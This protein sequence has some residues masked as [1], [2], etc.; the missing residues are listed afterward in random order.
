MVKR[1]RETDMIWLIVRY[2]QPT[3]IT[4]FR[5]E[6]YREVI[7]HQDQKR[8]LSDLFNLGSQKHTLYKSRYGPQIQ[9]HKIESKATFLIVSQANGYP[10][11]SFHRWTSSPSSRSSYASSSRAVQI[12]SNCNLGRAFLVLSSDITN[13]LQ[14][15]YHASD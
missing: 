3:I 2:R 15:S 8:E 14:Q 12:G 11:A 10:C 6:T 4:S 7:I 5:I 9:V 1:G 13:R